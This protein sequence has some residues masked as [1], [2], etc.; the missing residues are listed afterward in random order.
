MSWMRMRTGYNPQGSSVEREVEH[1]LSKA[2]LEA[3]QRT[4]RSL[5]DDE[6]QTYLTYTTLEASLR[7]SG[8]DRQANEVH[9]MAL[10]AK[11]HSIILSNIWNRL[12]GGR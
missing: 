4:I 6:G 10:D 7:R 8:L 5:I 1:N 3:I 12:T 9:K 2:E 11:N